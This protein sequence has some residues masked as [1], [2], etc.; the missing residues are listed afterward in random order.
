FIGLPIYTARNYF[1]TRIAV[2]RDR[3]IEKPEDLKGKKIGVPEYQQTSAIWARGA[4]QHEWGVQ[5][6]DIDWYMERTP[7]ISH[8]GSTGFK[9]PPGVTI[10]QIPLEKNIGQML[11]DG[12]LD[13][14]LLYL[15]KTNL[16]DRSTADIDTVCKPMFPDKVVES[17]RYYKKNGLYPINHC[18]VIK[19]DVHEKYPWAAVNIYHAFMQAKESVD[20]AV[21]KT[22]EDYVNCGLVE[23][24][25]L[26]MFD[27]D[28]KGYGLQNSRKVIETIAQYV[29]EQGLTDRLVKVEELFGP[30]MMEM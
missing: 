6:S 11:L 12:E 7:E 16:V 24:G 9:A 10:N 28:P 18:M 4:L 22:M 1:H 2:R 27:A 3:G 21:R 26:T 29:F 8:G 13:G 25:A 17:T 20:A 5:A 19:R 14:T 30:A 15:K 23:R